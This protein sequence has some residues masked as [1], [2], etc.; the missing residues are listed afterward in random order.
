MSSKHFVGGTTK[1]LYKLLQIEQGS[2]LKEIKVAYK[3]LA[4]VLHPDRTKGDASKTQQFRDVSEAYTIL[5]NDLSRRQYDLQH[6]FRY[7]KNRR[8][9]PPKNYR[10]VYRPVT[11]PHVKRTFDHIR[12]YEMHYGQGMMDDA[13][14]EAT[15]EAKRNGVDMGYQS[16][17]GK[18]FTFGGGINDTTNPYAKASQKRRQAQ[19]IMWEYEEGTMFDSDNKSDKAQAKGTIY[20]RAEI[21]EDL[22]GRRI[23]RKAKEAAASAQKNSNSPFSGAQDESC[24]IS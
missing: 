17:L 13:I 2:S 20:R 23:I 18:G 4:L 3:K 19:S 9:A 11:P 14:K 7:N 21:V 1:D 16:P 15:R 24:I 22:D 12:H 5:S 10:K 6:G 8:T